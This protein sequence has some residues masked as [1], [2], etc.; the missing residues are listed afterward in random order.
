[1]N[2]EEA[3]APSGDQ[4]RKPDSEPKRKKKEMPGG[5]WMRCP[6]C[7]N[8]IFRRDV[9]RGHRCCPECNHHF[10]L[11][12]RERIAI[13]LDEGLFAEFD[14]DLAPSDPLQFTDLK[15]YPDR[16]RAAQDKTGLKDAIMVGTGKL[17]GRQVVLALMEFSFIGGSMG[18]VVGEKIAR[19]FEKAGELACPC[20][21]FTS[22]GGARM[23]EGVISLMQMAKTC[24]ALARFQEKGGLFLSVLT[25]PSTGGVLASFSSLGDVVLAEPGAVIGFAGPRVIQNTIKQE[26]PEG[27]QRSE[28]MMKHGFIDRIVHRKDLRSELARISDLILGPMEPA[29]GDKDPT[30]KGVEKDSDSGGKREPESGKSPEGRA[31]PEPRP[32]SRSRARSV[33]VEKG[34]APRV[35]KDALERK[36]KEPGDD[37]A[38]GGRRRSA[39][40]ARA[41]R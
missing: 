24:A 32:T 40:G 9:E 8:M 21:V 14:A 39:G 6:A 35:A 33:T 36:A 11:T 31:S 22:S 26:L 2:R 38:K 20:I 19:A 18:Y 4:D 12:A 37:K 7:E 16:L 23:M 28:F 5:L 3:T 41:D 17:E 34:S 27:F 30:D 29:P 15:A 25:D 13:T 10:Q 1:M